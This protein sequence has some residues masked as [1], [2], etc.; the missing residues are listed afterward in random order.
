MTMI[1]A[2]SPAPSS[3]AV[4]AAALAPP[5]NVEVEADARA[6]DDTPRL[7]V[8]VPANT[9][10]EPRSLAYGTAGSEVAAAPDS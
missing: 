3:A 2:A 10:V 4:G 6:V 1:P 7:N 5:D 9:N 8:G